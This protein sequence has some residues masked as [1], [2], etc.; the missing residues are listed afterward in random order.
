MATRKKA[1]P[2]KA[3]TPPM[4][5][6]VWGIGTFYST[7]KQ[8]VVNESRYYNEDR[9]RKGPITIIEYQ[10]VKLHVMEAMFKEIPLGAS[11]T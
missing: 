1:A 11:I 2:I 5:P 7:N 8:A 4:P 9:G 10:P 3:K 6:T